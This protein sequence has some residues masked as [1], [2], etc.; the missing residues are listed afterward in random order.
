MSAGPRGRA[1][2]AARGSRRGVRLP[3][4]APRL[5][6]GA[7]R[8]RSRA[9]FTIIELMVV[10]VI[11]VVLAAGIA[12]GLGTLRK[13]EAVVEVGRL[14]S[15]IRLV[16]QMSSINATP[17]RLAIDLNEASWW[18]EALEHSDSPCASFA[19]KDVRREDD[20]A[21]GLDKLTRKMK[22]GGGGETVSERETREESRRCD[23]AEQDA[24]GKCPP[25]GFAALEEKLFQP[26]KLPKGVRFKGVMT[27][28][29]Q[30]IQREGKA[31]VYFFPD[32]SAEKAYIYVETVALNEDG[33]RVGEDD[34]PVLTIETFPLLGKVK[35]HTG[36]LSLQGVLRDEQ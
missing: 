7:G 36:E 28:H 1:S 35:V 18:V 20:K 12:I 11:I 8:G 30:D 2:T 3:D 23:P 10:L 27:T 16:Y 33:E 15:A 4:G 25:Q 17:Y 14:D 34:A 21:Y 9:G 26:R 13:A 22:Q 6:G 31:Y 29:Q 24:E 5:A 19:V 32:G